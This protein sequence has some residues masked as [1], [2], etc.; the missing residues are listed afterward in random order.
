MIQSIILKVLGFAALGGIAILLLIVLI[1]ALASL[2]AV[3]VAILPISKVPFRYNLRNLQAR[4]KT[5]VL[6]AVAFTVVIFLVVF[7]LAW[8]KGLDQLAESSGNP[9]NVMVL[10]DGATDEAWSNLPDA[11]IE[12]LPQ[13]IQS[14]VARD[15]KNRVMFSKEVYILAVQELP[16][17]NRKRRFVQ[18]RGLSDMPLA[19][20]V[21]EIQLAPGGAWPS[22]AGAREVTY[23]QGGSK[24]TATLSEIVLGDGV[25][26][27][28]GRDIG[29]QSLVAGDTVK[30]GNYTW[31]ITGIMKATGSAFGSEVWA[32]DTHVGERFGKANRYSSFV[33]RTKDA[34]TAKLAAQA[35]KEYSGDLT[36]N[37]Q[38]EMEYYSKLQQN[39][40]QFSYAFFT[41]AIF[42]AIG[43]ALGVMNTMFAAIS[44]R[45]KDIG[46][47]RLL[48]YTRLQI[49]CSFLLESLVIAA[50]GGLV[51][52]GL[53]MLANGWTFTSI[54][55]SGQASKSVVFR[56]AV[57][58]SVMIT[59]IALTFFM[60]AV[61]GFIPSISAMRLKPLE[62]LR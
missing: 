30:I 37:A 61:G 23:D 58:S 22:A 29:K 17:G 33:V 39:N 46:V 54:I 44:Q 16:S 38:T 60:G 10:S 35:L 25:A 57:D 2:A 20:N 26:A 34:Q 41:I 24:V 21:H 8:V 1:S 36:F 32:R 11:R 50:I 14:Y 15:E 59:A 53:G 28:F 18:L 62:S 19:A 56:L 27:T 3:L 31:Y 42:M 40:R 9:G 5:S 55:S 43:G 47:M 7:M 48:G 51:G 49:L 45:K 4:W 52:L 13:D 6:T 12:Q